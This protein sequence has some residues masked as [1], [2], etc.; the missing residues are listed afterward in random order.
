MTEF[1]RWQAPPQGLGTLLIQLSFYMACGPAE[2][3]VPNQDNLLFDVKRIWQIPDDVLKITVGKAADAIPFLESDE[4]CTYAPYLSGDVINLHGR[5]FSTGKKNKP[6]VALCMHHGAGLGEDLALKSMPFNKYAT[7]EEY[8]KISHRLHRL[9]YD[10]I[11]INRRGINIE[12][13]TY[14]LNE[15]CEFVIGYEGGLHHLAHCL[16]IP[17]IVLPWKYD[18][19]GHDPTYPGIL[20]E[21]HRFHAD[22]KTHFLDTVDSFLDMSNQ[23][24]TD[25][26]QDLHNNRGNN[27]LFSPG[28]SFD[29]ATLK[30]AY[31]DRALNLDL[32]PRICWCETRGE[33][34]VKIIK[35]K[36]PLE[37]MI[38][39]G[40]I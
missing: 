37:R 31:R 11:M 12:Q 40:V 4:L 24:I 34:T 13:K 5:E 29:A 22:R 25:L 39:Y 28:V 6:C 9:G 35:E 23:Q 14:L 18:D 26:V 36:L 20:Y 38:R 16:K 27:L 17:S 33:R 7:M 21:T 32:T 1:T 2:V 19:M 15:L 10:V 30:I 3:L 8:T